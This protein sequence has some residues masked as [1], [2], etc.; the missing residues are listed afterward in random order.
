MELHIEA[1]GHLPVH[2]QLREQIRF[3]ILNGDLTPGS[4]LPPARQLA[5]FLHVN[6]NTVQRAYRELAQ[7]GLVECRQGRGCVVIAHVQPLTPRASADLLEQVDNL[8]LRAQM[9][10]MQPSEVAALVLTRARHR[11][12]HEPSARMAFVECEA[13]IAEAV[14]RSIQE[15]LGFSVQPL[16]LGELR[17]APGGIEAALRDVPVVA[18][19]FFHIQELRQALARTRKEV[20]ALSVKPQLENLIQ[21]AGIPRGTRVALV[22]ISQSGAQ[23]LHR[24]LETS[25]ITGL[26]AVL[27]GVDE[28]QRLQAVLPNCPVIV[29]S[30]F[31]ADA[32][33]PLVRPGQQ[34]I[35][36]DYTTLDEAAIDFLRVVLTDGL[37][38]SDQ[39]VTHYAG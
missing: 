17:V 36:L 13:P 3:L 18:T 34:L 10:G 32:V 24:S 33:R 28:P 8:L 2:V 26:E 35:V 29:V 31:V 5:G 39:G 27:V 30:D 38:P 4:R 23:E 15:R 25:G 9:I 14:A 22:C 19:T 12:R 7:E 21:V 37:P 11:V 1:G 6:R 20:I 16:V